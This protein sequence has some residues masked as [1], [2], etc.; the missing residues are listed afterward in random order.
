M[1]IADDEQTFFAFVESN[2][3][4][5]FSNQVKIQSMNDCEFEIRTAYSWKKGMTVFLIKNQ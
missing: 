3:D 5:A 4:F 1:K 2:P